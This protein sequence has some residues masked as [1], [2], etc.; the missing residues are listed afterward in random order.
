MLAC[1]LGI[2]DKLTS[3]R[4]IWVVVFI[5]QSLSVR[6]RVRI[7]R[8]IVVQRWEAV[9][10]GNYKGKRRFAL[11]TSWIVTVSGRLV[12]LDMIMIL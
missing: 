7:S 10:Y 5:G 3:L 11:T 2:S 4:N 8:V 12:F 9:R 6:V 1:L